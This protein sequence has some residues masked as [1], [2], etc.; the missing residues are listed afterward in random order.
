MRRW[1]ETLP[2]HRKLVTMALAVTTAALLI[3]TLG[4][5][6]LDVWSFRARATGEAETLA[7]IIA[8]NT[9]AAVVFQDED[10]ARGTLASARIRDVVQRT[11]VYLRD[12][13]LFAGFSRTPELACPLRLPTRR[14][15]NLVV[16]EATIVTR[17][18]PM[19]TVYVERNISDIIQ[20]VL[21]TTSAGG[22]MLVLA[23]ALAFLLAHRVHRHVS[24]PIAQLAS[25]AR[26][27]GREPAP[28]LPVIARSPDEIGDLVRA[29]DEMVTRV[30]DANQRLSGS[31][32][33]LQREV[34]ERRRVEAE[35]EDLLVRERQASR[36]KDE[37][38]AA[39]SH[40]LRTPLNAISGWTQ[41]LARAPADAETSTKAI[42]S[43]ARNV[44]AQARVIEDLVDVSRIATGKLHLRLEPI[45]L[46]V[47]VDA[48][49][50]AVAATARAKQVRLSVR[51]PEAPCLVNGDADR[52]Q[53][54]AWNLLFNAVK[55]TPGEGVVSVTL[56]ETGGVY[57]LEVA[58]TGAG[59]A[60]EFLPHVFE[61]F[62]QADGSM[63]REHGGLGLGLAIVRELT[64]LHGGSITVSS[65]GRGQGATFTLRLPRLLDTAAEGQ[66]AAGTWTEA[67]MPSLT[68]LG[69]VV[70]DDNADALDVLGETLRGAGASVRAVA[71][72]AE[73]VRQWETEPGD[74]LLCDLAMPHMNGFEVLQR[75]RA[76]DALH[77]R[78]TRAIAVSAHA[79][80][81]HRT[82]SLNAGFRAHVSK[83]FATGE[84]IRIVADAAA[85]S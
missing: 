2:V 3:A 16:G 71:S 76:L 51:V 15:W 61:R 80:R 34:E 77:G 9:A 12:G 27:I 18:A 37:F 53:Q 73:A 74:V 22:A 78:T 85:R 11:C 56:S 81:D 17:G 10:A 7:Q 49:A 72:G 82:E 40:E 23:G 6:A 70:V 26:T 59:I 63:A 52:L 4:L 31:N 69:V 67:P 41:V 39:V 21:V 38:L 19:G 84:L 25:A 43:I 5:V 66:R 20:R 54:V 33:A 57:Q 42:E 28:A 45:D 36:L 24:R 64:E 47:P 32:E 75:I 55:F 68:G 46:R 8:E 14:A 62:R 1:F 58:D 35:R 79:S 60:P 83:P 44:R 48:A 29:F 65:A 30:H 50:D 13:S